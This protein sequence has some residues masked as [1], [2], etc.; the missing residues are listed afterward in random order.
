MTDNGYG[1][2]EKFMQ[3]LFDP[4]TRAQDS[5]V[6]KVQGTGLGMAITKNIVELMQGDIQVHSVVGQG[7][8]F[9]VTL[10]LPI[11]A[12]REQDVSFDTLLLL[13]NSEGLVRNVTAALKDTRV[14]CY[15]APNLEEAQAVLD[16]R[17]MDVVLL[18]GNEDFAGQL[19]EWTGEQTMIF[20]MED[21]QEEPAQTEYTDGVILSP[22][23]LSRLLLAVERAQSH[24]SAE[25]D[26]HSILQGMHFL[27][28]EDNELNAEI[29]RSM[30]E[31]YGAGCA[32]YPDGA[33][34]VQAFD[35]VQPGDYDAILMD[36]QMPRMN[37]LEAT[38]AI[39]AST[40][41]LGKQIPIIA[42]TANAFS[43]DVRQSL[44]AGMDAHISKPIDIE[45]LER[46]MKRFVTP[47][48][49]VNRSLKLS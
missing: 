49:K 13:S 5:T 8:R 39:R 38:R 43:E 29:L 24:E 26:T 10:T 17:Q 19:R 16:R 7:S 3:H 11:D 18:D 45:L 44:S 32:I 15:V 42:M 30:L 40:N 47:R 14:A 4:F 12:N 2:D 48:K 9:D 41:P 25:D 21:E 27:C 36:V 37:G 28:A 22:F 46:T 20:C 31:M 6:N 23:F 33:A 35:K 34:L 1:I